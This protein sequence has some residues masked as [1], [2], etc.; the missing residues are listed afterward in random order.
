MANLSNINN[1]FLF[2]DGDFLKIGNLAPINNISGTE[3]G[4][5]ITNSNVAS[6]TLDNTAA[7]GKKYVMYSDDGGKLNFYDADASSGRLTIDSSGNSTFAGNVGIGITPS[8]S[9]SGIE[10]LQI[11][12]GMTLY[13][14][15]GDRAT[16]A[17]NLIVN[18]GTAF[19]YVINGLA[20]RFSIEDGYMIWGTA[21]TGT[22]G[23]VATVTTRMTLMNDGR[24]GIGVTPSYANVP[25]H[26]KNIGGGN[27]FNIFEGIG[28]AW[29]FGEN[30]DTGTKYCQV[31]GRYG[32][33]SGINV[34]LNGKVGIGTT[35]PGS[36]DGEA[37]NLVVYD[38]VT[39]GITIALPQTTAAGS[40]RGSILFS[41]GTSGNQKYRGGVIY[42]H[43][44]GMGGVADTMYLRA[45]VNSYLA[46]DALGN[47]GIGTKTPRAVGSGYKGL[48]V[49]SPS[50][51]SSLWLSGFS[52]TTKGYLA[53][54]TGGLNL[55][56]ISNH[57][58]TFGTNNSPKMTILS[59]GNVGI[60]VTS[61][62]QKLQVDGGATGFNQGIPAT[63]GATQNGMLRLTSGS[64]V[65]GET[66]D[67]GMNVAPTYAWIQ[68]TNKGSLAVNYNLALNP[69]GG[70]VGIG[71]TSPASILHI[72][73]NSAGPTQLSIQSNDFTRAEEINFLNPS[74]SAISGQIKYY[75]N[76]TVEYMSFS[77][78]NNSA[79]LQR[80]SILSTGE[81]V[82]G[83]PT[84]TTI[85]TD[86]I[87]SL[88][89]VNR[90]GL[91]AAMYARFVMQ[92]RT[93]K[94]ISFVNGTPT[95]YG[96]IAVSGSGVSYGSNSD[97]RLK[98]NILDLTN[99]INKVK[100]LSPKTFNFIDRPDTTVTGFLAHEV[101]EIVSEAVT[102]EKDGT[103]T[104]GN[105]INDSDGTI[106]EQNITEPEKLETGT[107]FTAIKTEPEYQQ[108]DQ[109]KLVPILIGALKELIAK[110]EKL[111]NK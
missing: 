101:Q 52:D 110:V 83:A 18:T 38:A 86:A 14:G 95:H 108:L 84:T 111:E 96:T 34:D 63:S 51:G 6:I 67:F 75:T 25:L 30:D 54:D 8:A 66:F 22:A 103:I 78:S 21:P 106:L 36:Y 98:E 29:V 24:V 17:S 28:N 74:T 77:T 13:G 20:G 4:I 69:N 58:L 26:T 2:T 53:M 39:P 72:K 19:E 73:D 43:G 91:T 80:M 92:E 71:E 93:G 70:N 37:D 49:S 15:S 76:P 79:A 87:H 104:T 94:W 88:G 23:Q 102:G 47:V 61:P 46:L 60:G 89:S 99:S 56:A 109:A 82:I 105:V 64:S 27:S 5:S 81:F 48:E 32:H 11:G 68:A 85:S 62:S 1:K 50:S 7:S 35:S 40:A 3:S 90:A 41:D 12:G 31:A 100:L 16:M 45:A 10:V 33:H 107:S 44:T 42:D 97:Y 65:F 9:F 59:G 57:S 55:T